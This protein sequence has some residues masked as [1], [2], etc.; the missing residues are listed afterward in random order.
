MSIDERL[1]TGLNANTEH[2]V[3]DLDLEL[4]STLRRAHRRSRARLAGTS[5]VATAAV[6]GAAWLGGLPGVDRGARPVDPVKTPDTARVQPRDMAG[7]EGRL[8][9]GTYSMPV[10]EDV[11][12]AGLPRVLVELPEGYFTNGGWVIDAGSATLEPDEFGEVS[13]W[14]VGRAVPDPC[15]S[16]EQAALG[17]G[18]RDLARALVSQ[19]GQTTTTPRRVTLD[20]RRGLYLEVTAPRDA[21]LAGCDGGKYALWATGSDSVY[22]QDTPGVVNH[23]WILDVDG[24]RLVV[25]VANYPDQTEEQHRELL[26][27]ARTMRFVDP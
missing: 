25:A 6:A 15:T 12:G 7:L 16:T 8:E 23:L 19:P 20:G 9:P 1:H 24:N 21:E 18:V 14:Q 11:D 27:I 13:V 17:N 22:G 26:D 3:P 2:L 5:L 4:G 10:W